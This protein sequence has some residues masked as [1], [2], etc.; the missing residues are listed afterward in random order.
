MWVSLKFEKDSF[1]EC[2]LPHPNPESLAAV[3][4]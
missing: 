1:K 4:F 2:G 3:A